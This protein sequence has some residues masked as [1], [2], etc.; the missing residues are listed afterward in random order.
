MGSCISRQELPL[1]RLRER[2]S[3]VA[4]GCWGWKRPFW[5]KSGLVGGGGSGLEGFLPTCSVLLLACAHHALI[6][7]LRASVSDGGFPDIK[8]SEELAPRSTEAN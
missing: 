5:G 4:A 1:P 2:K 7:P 6:W 3:C 8:R